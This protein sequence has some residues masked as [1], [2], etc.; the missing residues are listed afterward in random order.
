V[1]S[2]DPA[3]QRTRSGNFALRSACLFY[4]QFDPLRPGL[5]SRPA[6]FDFYQNPYDVVGAMIFYDKTERGFP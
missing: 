2:I 6:R 5:A 1:L 4:G 3:R